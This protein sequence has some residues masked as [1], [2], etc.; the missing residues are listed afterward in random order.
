MVGAN[1]CHAFIPLNFLTITPK[2]QLLF[3]QPPF[4]GKGLA[5][6]SNL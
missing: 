6:V 2:G 5:K 1:T 4:I 3:S